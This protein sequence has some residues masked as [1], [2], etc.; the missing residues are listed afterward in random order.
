MCIC[1][2]E[3]AVPEFFLD[4]TGVTTRIA[5]VF[6]PWWVTLA[7]LRTPG[8]TIVPLFLTRL[9]V[10]GGMDKLYRRVTIQLLGI[11][12]RKRSPRIQGIGELLGITKALL[13]AAEILLLQHHIYRALPVG[14]KQ[15]LFDLRLVEHKK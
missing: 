2:C 1:A 12:A 11:V 8:W 14:V 6:K 15:V 10:R 13:F 9:E 4:D 7:A 3:F 5:T